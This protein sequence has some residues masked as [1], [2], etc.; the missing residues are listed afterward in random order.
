MASALFILD[1]KGKVIISRDYRGEVDMSEIDRF[2]PEL[3]TMEEE[4]RQT[5]IV[6]ME[7]IYFFYVKNSGLFFVAAAAKNANAALI[8]IFLHRTISLFKDYF[9]ELAEESIRDNFVVLFCFDAAVRF[10]H[11]LLLTSPF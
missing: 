2:M 5:P 9:K 10:F 6:Q 8:F 4:S 11:S 3:S 7:N 1:S